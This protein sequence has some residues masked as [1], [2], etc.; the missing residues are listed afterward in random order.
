MTAQ[1]CVVGSGEYS[2]RLLQ[3]LCPTGREMVA[4]MEA[5]FDESGTHS[6]SPVMC[7]SGCLFNPRNCRKL[8]KEWRA[9]LAKIPSPEGEGLPVD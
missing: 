7:V 8:I 4:V 1:P 9:E 5:Y 2:D 6:G 3:I